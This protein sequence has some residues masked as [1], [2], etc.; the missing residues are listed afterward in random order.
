MTSWVC[1]KVARTAW[2]YDDGK[3][4]NS[5]E[6]NSLR[7]F[8]KTCFYRFMMRPYHLTTFSPQQ[9]LAGLGLMCDIWYC[10]GAVGCGPE[11]LN[12][13][14]YNRGVEGGVR[15]GGS[16]VYGLAINR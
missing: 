12:C 13:T 9:F 10:N 3:S 2:P 4:S 6:A 5:P 14:N 7:F 16:Y 11:G 15:Q 1:T 8:S